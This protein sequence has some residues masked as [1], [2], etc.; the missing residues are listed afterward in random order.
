M[1]P[2]SDLTVVSPYSVMFNCNVTANPRAVIQWTRNGI[3]LNTTMGKFT[4]SYSTE[5]DCIITDPHNDCVITST[6]DI[7]DT[8]PNDSGEYMCTAINAAG[9]DTVSVSL[10]VYGKYLLNRP[11]RCHLIYI[12][13][14]HQLTCNLATN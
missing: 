1:T 4:I 12:L 3:V 9:N 10:T 8:V 2:H 5:G 6:L 13:T 14:V 11:K 7:V